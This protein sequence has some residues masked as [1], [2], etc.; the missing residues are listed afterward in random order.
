MNSENVFAFIGG[1]CTAGLIS[2][3]SV[4]VWYLPIPTEKSK[5]ILCKIQ[6]STNIVEA[7]KKENLIIRGVNYGTEADTAEIVV[8][9]DFLYK[10]SKREY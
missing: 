9:H 2:I 8:E 1:F 4:I 7:L 3:M 5:E 10:N 6:Q